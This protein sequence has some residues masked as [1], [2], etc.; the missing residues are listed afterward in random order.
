MVTPYGQMSTSWGTGEEGKGDY[1]TLLKTAGT[2]YLESRQDAVRQVGI[3]EERLVT[4]ENMGLK[5]GAIY[6]R[7][8]AE[9]AA[10]RRNA[11][12]Q[13]QEEFSDREWSF[14]GKTGIATG[15]A[16]GIGAL[17]LLLVASQRL[18]K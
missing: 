10:A 4:L 6:R 14:L 1:S 18:A 8:E 15:I 7:T 2:A 13:L 3:L 17:V 16:V 9:L 12:L 11:Q 5:G